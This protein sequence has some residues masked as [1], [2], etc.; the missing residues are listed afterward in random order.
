MKKIYYFLFSLLLQVSLHGETK[1]EKSFFIDKESAVTSQNVY[2]FRDVFSPLSDDNNAFGFVSS[3]VWIHLKFTNKT[4]TTQSN[5]IE[6][7]YPLLDYIEVLEYKDEKLIQSYLTGDLTNFDTRKE[8]SNTFVIPYKLQEFSSKEFIIGI[9]SQGPLNLKMNFMSKDEYVKSSKEHAMILGFYYGAV[10]IMLIYN[11]ILFFMIKERVY[12]YYVIFHFFYIFTQLSINGLAFEYLYPN[13]PEINLYFFLSTMI[14][15]NISA[16]IFS[17]SFLSIKNNYP[18]LYGYLRILMYLF[19]ALL[20]LNFILAYEIMAKVVTLLSILSVSSLFLC[21]VYILIKNNTASSRFFVIA[22]GFLLFGSLLTEFS[23]LGFLPIN[24]FTLYGTQIGAFIE[25]SLFS[26][27]LA[28]RYNIVFVKLSKKE[29]ELRLFN[30]A[31]EETVRQRTQTI[32]DNNIQLSKEINNKN[33]LHK[34]LFHRVKNNLQ[35]MSGILHMQSKNVQDKKAQEVLQH[36]IQTISSM[37][38]IHEKLYNSANLEAVDFEQYLFELTNYVRVSLNTKKVEFDIE[39]KNMML[40]LQSAVPLGLIINEIIT[41]SFKHAFNDVDEGDMKIT[42][43]MSKDDENNVMLKISDNGAGTKISTLKKNFGFK[44]IES[45]S[46]YQLDASMEC[47]SING[48][49]Y[50]IKFKDT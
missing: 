28:Y 17:T 38:I 5:I 4:D 6:F 36:S 35:M 21:G 11:M 27:A 29:Q 43:Q 12:L 15:A 8:E 23:F 22:W 14:L 13:K 7:P 49:F 9:S 24:F 48:F 47:S 46:N 10:L 37:G 25:L 3:T 30:E 44:L 41:N 42:I 32:N 31:L 1:I 40:T 45:L 33:I 18:R 2:N 19:L 20:G 34:E 16:I 39:C 26:I 50:T